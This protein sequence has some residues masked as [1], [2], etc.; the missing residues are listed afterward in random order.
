MLSSLEMVSEPSGKQKT[1]AD[2]IKEGAIITPETPVHTSDDS[3]ELKEYIESMI[4]SVGSSPWTVLA[5]T[6]N[7]AFVTNYNLPEEIENAFSSSD[8]VYTDI[9][10]MIEDYRSTSDSRKLCISFADTFAHFKEMFNVDS[11]GYAYA[12]NEISAQ[13]NCVALWFRASGKSDGHH[14]YY[15]ETTDTTVKGYPIKVKFMVR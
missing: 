2:L 3:I 8:P 7:Q 6:D 5:S 13:G 9:I 15:V 10:I 12:G 14:R 11:Q 4:P 1:L